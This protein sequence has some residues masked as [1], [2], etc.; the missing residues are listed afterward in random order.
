MNAWLSWGIPVIAWLQGL[1]D[2]L[3]QP[4]EFFTF[5]GTEEFYMLV[6]PVVLW[7]FDVGLGIRLALILLASD[8]LNGIFKT[9]FGWP[10]PYWVSDQIRALSSETSFG[11]PSG[12]AQN[13]LALWGQLAAG[14]RRR[15]ATVVLIVLIFLISIS[16]L[17]LAVHFPSDMLAGW[18]VAGLLL[19]GF[20][21]YGP[22]IAQRLGRLSLAE[23][24]LVSLGAS[25][26]L[27]ALHLL[28]F[29]MTAGRAVPAE[30]AARAAAAVP[31][32]DPIEPRSLEGIFSSMGM[33]FGIGG[34]ASLLFAWGKFDAKGDWWKR[35]L[36]FIVGLAGVLAL[37]MGL[38]VVFPEG[39]TA[40]ALIL[41]YVRYAAVGFWA[42]Y[43]AP[44]VFALIRLV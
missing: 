15:W 39:E 17:Y 5:L 25:L 31:G 10:R 36:R 3:R 22:P 28:V 2:W 27:L 33:L 38:R 41:R 20:L 18:V 8:G 14:V 29:W 43:L 13:A 19:W 40:I 32:A 4:M 9:A 21:R 23:K 16:R 24:V 6:M 7:C 30:W 42:V 12:H 34:G 11:L 37:W 35:V 26:L 1:G 44:R